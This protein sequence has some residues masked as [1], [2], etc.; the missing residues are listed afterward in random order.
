MPSIS[1]TELFGNFMAACVNLYVDFILL[2]NVFQQGYYYWCGVFLASMCLPG[3]MMFSKKMSSQRKW[4][5]PLYIFHPVSRVVYPILIFCR[6]GNFTTLKVKH[7]KNPQ[8][9][10]LS[11]SKPVFPLIKPLILRI[12][13]TSFSSTSTM[14]AWANLQKEWA[15]NSDEKMIIGVL[16]WDLSAAFCIQALLCFGR[17]PL[18][19]SL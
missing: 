8:K 18:S 1:S 7:N 14:T 4:I 5:S 17:F 10:S 19:L 12:H 2:F 16:L 6:R 3:L 15:R 9:K 13:V 11:T